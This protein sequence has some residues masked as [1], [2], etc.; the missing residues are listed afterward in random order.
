MFGGEGT[1][2]TG[3]GDEFVS[4]SLSR[5]NALGSAGGE[6]LSSLPFVSEI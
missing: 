6:S 1:A 5:L 3:G 2:G 4:I